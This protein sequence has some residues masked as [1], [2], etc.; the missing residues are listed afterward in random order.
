MSD[1]STKPLW[2]PP[3]RRPDSPSDFRDDSSSLLTLQAR[4]GRWAASTF[5]PT[6]A[7]VHAA[8]MDREMADV[9]DCVAI[10]DDAGLGRAIAGVVVVALALA[11]AQDIDLAAALKAEQADNEAAQWAQTSW[12]QWV[13]SSDGQVPD[14]EISAS[15][16]RLAKHEIMDAG[17]VVTLLRERGASLNAAVAFLGDL[18]VNIQRFEAP[19]PIGGTAPDSLEKTKPGE[20]E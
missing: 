4:I 2:V 12:G 18:G 7:A 5:G 11:D 15:L 14:D 19:S 1:V 9:H 20:K 6:P 17:D 8:R 16:G 3:E 13:R 10:G